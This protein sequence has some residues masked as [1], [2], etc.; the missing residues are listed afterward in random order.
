MREYETKKVTSEVT[1][2]A[3]MSCDLCGAVAKGP[4]R[5]WD[6]DYYA[7][8]ETEVEIRHKKGS[9][10]P[11]GSSGTRYTFDVCPKCFHEKLIPWMESQGA[12]AKATDYSY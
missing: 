5:G 10:Y 12:K 2:L 4:E 6:A 1:R 3:K 11:E 8:D 9:A 7:D